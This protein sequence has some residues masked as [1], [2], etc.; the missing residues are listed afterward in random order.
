MTIAGTRA[1]LASAWA[2]AAMVTFLFVLSVKI[3]EGAADGG[4]SLLVISIGLRLLRTP[5]ATHAV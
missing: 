1:F 3:G 2:E 5:R 4:V